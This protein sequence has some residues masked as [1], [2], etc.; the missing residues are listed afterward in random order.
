MTKVFNN[1]GRLRLQD[2]NNIKMLLNNDVPLTK[3]SSVLGWSYSTCLAVKKNDTYKAYK[4]YVST[5]YVKP[6]HI[7]VSEPAVANEQLPIPML[8]DYAQLNSGLNRLADAIE[9]LNDKVDKNKRR[10]F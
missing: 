6:V 5:R 3:V 8:P 9:T 10:L 4:D 1:G 2:F 7:A